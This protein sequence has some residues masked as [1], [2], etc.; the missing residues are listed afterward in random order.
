M[1]SRLP[2][3]KIWKILAGLVGT[4]AAAGLAITLSPSLGDI[5]LL[6][7][8]F[9]GGD[10]NQIS[11]VK[12]DAYNNSSKT[13][14][15]I[16]VTGNTFN[17]KFGDSTPYKEGDTINL[18]VVKVNQNDN[19][20]KVQI[21]NSIQEQNNITNIQRQSSTTFNSQT[22]PNLFSEG[23]ST[24]SR[25]LLT[26]QQSNSSGSFPPSTNLYESNTNGSF[27]PSA[28]LYEWSGGFGLNRLLVEKEAIYD[29]PSG[30]LTFLSPTA[31]SLT[32]NNANIFASSG[33]NKGSD[34]IFA[35]LG[36]LGSI[37]SGDQSTVSPN[38]SSCP[39]K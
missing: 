37:F 7:H 4:A 17:I 3:P 5:H 20:L 11:N 33:D 30:S 21:D 34:S 14:D 18:H 29:H 27:L 35:F 32:Q 2:L 9:T 1:G 25:E 13:G 31:E 16:I 39:G 24:E 15:T 10:N 38:Y 28:N 19:S 8:L 36:S 22:V 23:S 6:D 26:P 12:G